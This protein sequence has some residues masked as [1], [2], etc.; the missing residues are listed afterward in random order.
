MQIIL[1]E[2][3]KTVHKRKLGSS[4]R[5]TVCGVTRLLAPDKFQPISIELAAVEYN[6]NKCGRCFDGEGGY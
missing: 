4:D 1:N 6:A 3:T 5:H 2:F